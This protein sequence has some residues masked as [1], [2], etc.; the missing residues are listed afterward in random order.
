MALHPVL[1][2]RQAVQSTFSQLGA[3]SAELAGMSEWLLVQEGRYFGRTYSAGPLTAMWLA[4]VNLVQFYGPDGEMLR[5]LE[6]CQQP[7]TSRQAA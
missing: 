4:D 3:S 2:V 6:V 1:E 7:Q 5:T